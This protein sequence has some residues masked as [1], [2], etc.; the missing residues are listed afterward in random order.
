MFVKQTNN[1]FFFIILLFLQMCEEFANDLV[2]PEWSTRES[3]LFPD[4]FEDRRFS[5]NIFIEP[6][7]GVVGDD[8]ELYK[9]PHHAHFSHFLMC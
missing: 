1:N 9:A 2:L 4:K 6:D 7:G 3:L 5:P 8:D